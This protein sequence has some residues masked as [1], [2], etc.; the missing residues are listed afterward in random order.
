MIRQTAGLRVSV[1]ALA[2]ALLSCT[3]A[4]SPLGPPSPLPDP[5]HRLVRISEWI[6]SEPS[7][8]QVSTLQYDDQ[9]RLTRYRFFVSVLGSPPRQTLMTEYSWSGAELSAADLY[10][11]DRTEP[12]ERMRFARHSDG[13]L[14]YVERLVLDSAGSVLSRSRDT[15]QLD[16]Y[17][18]ISA[19]ENADSRETFTYCRSS[20]VTTRDPCR[21]T[22]RFAD[23]ENFEHDFEYGGTSHPLKPAVENRWL[24]ILR[25]LDVTPPGASRSAS[26]FRVR[27]AG[28]ASLAS[29]V[30]VGGSVGAH[31][32]PDSV[33]LEVRNALSPGA[34]PTFAFAVQIRY[35]YEAI[36]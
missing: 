30:F 18:R 23:G 28:S 13:R 5:A 7:H 34:R 27:V 35:Q 10:L 31:G 17:G 29:E 6:E 4:D 20:H 22:L 19:V 26:A 8:S 1:L 25:I 36:P 2:S 15:V 33:R 14:S 21:I 32:M 11:V 9:G 3:S 16:A 12:Y 24:R